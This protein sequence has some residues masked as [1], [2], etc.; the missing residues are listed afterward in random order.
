[1]I[2]FSDATEA[3]MTELRRKMRKLKKMGALKPAQLRRFRS[4]ATD[5]ITPGKNLTNKE[6]EGLLREVKS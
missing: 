3:Q 6:A 4:L 2:D 5:L 1:M